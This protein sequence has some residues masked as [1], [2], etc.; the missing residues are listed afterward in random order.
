MG[1]ITIDPF[2]CQACGM[3]VV[4]CPVQAIDISLNSRKD[5]TREMEIGLT[6]PDRSGPSDPGMPAIVGFFD[7]HGNFGARH[8]EALK[9]DYPHVVPVMVFGVRRLDVVDILNAFHFG[10]DAVLVACCPPNRDPFPEARNKVKA[11]VVWTRAVLDAVGIGGDRLLVCD[12][13]EQG[14]VERQ[15]MDD[16]VEQIRKAVPDEGQGKNT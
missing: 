12:M 5:M 11:R 4:E 3:C 9:N 16:L 2:L 6:R 13:P 15:I 7:F 14:L 8:V 1:E 10:A